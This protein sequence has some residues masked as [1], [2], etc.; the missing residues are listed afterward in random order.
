MPCVYVLCAHVRTY[1]VFTLYTMVVKGIKIQRQIPW[2][3]KA[4]LK[5]QYAKEQMLNLSCAN[6]VLMHTQMETPGSV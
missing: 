3:L 2:G 6:Y 5:N 4:T 1:R